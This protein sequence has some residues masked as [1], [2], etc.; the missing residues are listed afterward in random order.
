M[1][2]DYRKVAEIVERMKTNL[3]VLG[4]GMQQPL[5]HSDRAVD[6]DTLRLLHLFNEKAQVFGVRGAETEDWLHRTKIDWAWALGCPSL[7][8]ST[9]TGLPPRIHSPTS[10]VTCL[11]LAHPSRQNLGHD[12]RIGP[13]Y[14]GDGRACSSRPGLAEPLGQHGLRKL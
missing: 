5:A 13:S 2:A 14:S 12:E 7:Y 4:I 9:F 3:I 8:P 11:F 10:S 6:P 1:G